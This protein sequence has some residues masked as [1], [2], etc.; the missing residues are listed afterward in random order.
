MAPAGTADTIVYHLTPRASST[1]KNLARLSDALHRAGLAEVVS[2]GDLVA[3]KV[4]FG[5]RGN[6]TYVHPGYVRAT[7][8]A[9]RDVGGLPI[10]MDSSTLYGGLRSNAHDHLETA[11]RNGF[12]YATVNAPIMML[13][14][15]RG[16]DYRE[17]EIPGS[18]FSRVQIGT[19]IL[20]ADSIVSLAHFKG[21]MLTGFGGQIKNLSMG[22]SARIGKLAM[23]ADVLPAV[24]ADKCTVCGTCAGVCPEGAITLEAETA[25]IDAAV[26]VGCGECIAS[27]PDRALAIP[28]GSTGERIQ[29]KMAE[30]ALGA[31]AGRQD[32]YLGV[33]FALDVTPDCDCVSWSDTP[34]VPDAGI[35]AGSDP[36][37]LDQAAY[38][39]CNAQPGLPQ[40]ALGAD[41]ADAPDKFSYVNDGVDPAV[42][43]EHGE[44]LGLGT[45]RYRLEALSGPE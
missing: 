30:F 23:H 29:R 6:V 26:C 42:Q 22:A 43:L 41:G 12:S 17:V 15:I 44:E 11:L 16:R 37:A 9:I 14:G 21:H 19:G 1:H 39:L 33:N 20:D 7:V 36:V 27:C 24:D 25:V 45:R 4:S 28:R 35:V 32:R 10:L 31:L 38:D 34:I 3:V 40:S 2:E 18:I 13:D 5:E 8:D